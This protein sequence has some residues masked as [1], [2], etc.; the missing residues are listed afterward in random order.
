VGY[1]VEVGKWN[2]R[3]PLGNRIVRGAIAAF[4]MAFALATW[5]TP[6]VAAFGAATSLV[7][8]VTA[9]TGRC[10]GSADSARCPHEEPPPGSGGG[11][12]RAQPRA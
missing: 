11:R 3:G 4:I 12:S 1:A 9:F 8:L 7:V 10:L 2:R 6:L 5:Q